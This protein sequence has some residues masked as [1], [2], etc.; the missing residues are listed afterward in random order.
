[1]APIIDKIIEWIDLRADANDPTSISAITDE[2]R[3]FIKS[4]VGQVSEKIL[5]TKP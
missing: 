2:E 3:T 5:P 1:M 4:L